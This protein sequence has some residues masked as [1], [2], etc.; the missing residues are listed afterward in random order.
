MSQF[1]T[2]N[3]K[4]KDKNILLQCLKELG[5][6][7]EEGKDLPL[8]GYLDDQRSQTADIVIRKKYLSSVSNDIGFKKTGDYY[9]LIISGYDRGRKIGKEIEGIEKKVVDIQNKIMRKY[10]EEKVRKTM[11]SLK[12][13][14]FKLRKRSEKG[15][16]I[17]YEYVRM[18]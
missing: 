6:P 17:V 10:A 1:A 12:S 7:V 16:Q 2:I 8:Y 9:D 3:T 5:Y 4:I 11:E 18:T 13:K 15:K 14:G